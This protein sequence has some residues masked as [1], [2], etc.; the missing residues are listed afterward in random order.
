MKAAEDAEISV[1]VHLTVRLDEIDY[2]GIVHSSNY[3]KYME[4]ARVNPGAGLTAARGEP[5]S[6]ASLI[7]RTGVAR[8]RRSQGTHQ[9]GL[10]SVT[11]LA[12]SLPPAT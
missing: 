7:R 3:L 1:T 4:H 6:R 11:A 12:Q 5:L 8:A 2:L 9:G 10:P